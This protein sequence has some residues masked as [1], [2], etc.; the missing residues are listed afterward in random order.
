MGTD[1]QFPALEALKADA[2]GIDVLIEIGPP[3]VGLVAEWVFDI[4][5]RAR[6]QDLLERRKS[7]RE[8]YRTHSQR[9][10]ATYGSAIRQILERRSDGE[11]P[12]F[13][14]E[15]MRTEC[16]D[17]KAAL[18]DLYT[19]VDEDYLTRSERRRLSTLETDVSK[20]AEYVRNKTEFDHR[21]EE[22]EATRK[23]FERRFEPYEGGEKYMR[24]A[25]YEWLAAQSTHLARRL[26]DMARELVVPVLP[27]AD[28]NWLT[29][30][31]TRYGK[32]ADLLPQYN[33]KFVAREREEYA[34][35]LT[36]EHGELNDQ[37]QKAVVRNDRR[38]LVDASAGTG[39][40]LTL[41]AR[42]RYLLARGVS[43][44]EIVVL[45]Y[46]SDAATELQERIRATAETSAEALT[47]ST[48]HSYAAQIYY[49]VH[50]ATDTTMGE[51]REGLVRS[52]LEAA[53]HP[54][55][56]NRSD[57]R[58][59]DCYDRFEQAYAEY[60]SLNGNSDTE[61]SD[62]DNHA[63]GSVPKEE[64]ETLDEFITEA[65]TFDRS[66]DEIR[67]DIDPSDDETMDE[68]AAAFA[69]AGAALVEAYNA[70]VIE[71]SG[72][73][74]FDDLIYT[75]TDIVEAN[76]EQYATDVQHVLVDEF[77]DI[78]DAT[79]AFVD[80]FMTPDTDTHLFCVGDDWQSI[81]GF[82]GSNVRHFTTF[83][84]TYDEVTTTHLE[85]NYRCPPAV[86]DAGTEL[87]RQSSAPQNEKAVRAVSDVDTV[88]TLHKI[89]HVYEERVTPEVADLIEEKL[90]EY[91]LDDIMVL[92]RN[93]A[94]S[95]Y[96]EGLRDELAN[97][98]IPHRC[99]K[100]EDDYV[101][102]EHRSALPYDVAY[103]DKGFVKYD[104]PDEHADA[105]TQPP[106]VLT[107]SIHASKGTE[108]PVVI[109]LHAAD[110]T[111]DGLPQDNRTNESLKP[112]QA[113]PADR[114]P[115]G[116]R[117]CYVA[118]TRTEAELHAFAPSENP[119]RYLKDID[120]H[121]E[122]NRISIPEEIVGKCTEITY[123]NRENYPIK[124][125]LE[126]KEFTI[127]LLAWPNQNPPTLEAGEV[128]RLQVP[129]P[130]AQL[131]ESEFGLELRFD[132]TPVEHIPTAAGHQTPDQ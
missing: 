67:A 34:N 13:S 82:N 96:M 59:P 61:R 12:E 44:S 18:D 45:T 10:E 93:D 75:A 63:D 25:D 43:A 28:A 29:T 4:E 8:T 14:I 80:A 108:A 132:H 53:T 30:C 105:E 69:R 16:E 21:K 68:T 124:G 27:A 113:N 37:Q 106:R 73:L 131:E 121:L 123:P 54:E 91:D 86:V 23:A 66:A 89:Q 72:A 119:S 17:A 112:S 1:G 32:L 101:P 129:N 110:N 84:Q 103:D 35:V 26:A 90:V 99:P 51:A 98:G 95:Q 88:P 60:R 5:Y 65:R 79:L 22:I 2:E 36:T 125:T 48:I 7:I 117:L 56:Q 102:V 49:D 111:P 57:I 11:Q 85:Q 109:F 115:E 118:L 47:V 126:T 33:E 52:Y 41:T 81:Y 92:S 87:M 46:T 58:F 127:K 62:H 76:P 3:G 31:K 83:D 15:R 107:Q 71:E 78:S 50:D 74:D 94:K 128:Y 19:A 64:R 38:N 114:I 122:E 24:T 100:G 116:R 42:V 70:L 120:D 130:D 20:A 104:L 9:F 97:R 6:K 77:Q 39:K 55:Q 40:T